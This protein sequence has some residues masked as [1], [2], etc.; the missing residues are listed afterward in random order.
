[1]NNFIKGYVNDAAVDIVLDEVLELNPGFT[2][3]ELP[4][5]FTP[6]AGEVAFLLAR[7]S[8]AKKGIF[9]IPVAIDADYT[10]IIH[11]MIYNTTDRKVVFMPGDRAFSIVNL[12]LGGSRVKSKVAKIGTRYDNWDNSTGGTK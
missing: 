9:P 2:T 12:K 4:C 6:L 10:G 3:V 11:A 8:T 5:T 7:S 1:M